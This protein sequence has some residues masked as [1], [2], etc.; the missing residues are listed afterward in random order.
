MLGPNIIG[1]VGSS[2]TIF[3]YADGAFQKKSY[4]TMENGNVSNSSGGFDFNASRSNSIYSAS[5][6]VQPESNQVLII[7]KAWAAL[8]CTVSEVL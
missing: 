3:T 4:S 6:T 5:D 8:G 1:S 2:R 7:I